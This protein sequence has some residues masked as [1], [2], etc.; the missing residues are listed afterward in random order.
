MRMSWVG[1]FG[2]KNKSGVILHFWESDTILLGG[3]IVLTS[4]SEQI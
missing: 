4:V 3:T 2:Y 1:L